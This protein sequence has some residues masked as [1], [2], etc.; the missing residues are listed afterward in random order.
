MPALIPKACA[1]SPHAGRAPM[2]GARDRVF[3]CFFRQPSCAP[4][5]NRA[6]VPQI[7]ETA[8]AAPPPRKARHDSAEPRDSII[9]VAALLGAVRPIDPPVAFHESSRPWLGCRLHQE[10]KMPTREPSPLQNRRYP[11][12]CLHAFT[13]AQGRY[14]TPLASN[15]T[16]SHSALSNHCA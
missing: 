16:F 9:G 7:T 1:E 5:N 13:H 12:A 2:R 6:L 4:A 10:D 3:Y 14:S 11:Q 8:A 15:L